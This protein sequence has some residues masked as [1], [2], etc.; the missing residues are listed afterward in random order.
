MSEFE[1]VAIAVDSLHLSF[2]FPMAINSVGLICSFHGVRSLDSLFCS[3]CYLS[4]S[5]QWNTFS[6]IPDSSV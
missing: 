5:T 1:K 4:V 6:K 3:V 2:L